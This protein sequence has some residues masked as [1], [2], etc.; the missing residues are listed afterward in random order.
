MLRNRR[1]YQNSLVNSTVTWAQFAPE[2]SFL[3]STAIKV[4]GA[5]RQGINYERRAQEYIEAVVPWKELEPQTKYLKSPWLCYKTK[6]SGEQLLYC[7]PDGLIIQLEQKRCTIVEIKLQ[8]TSEAFYQIKKL[9]QPVLEKVYPDFVFSA[10]E[11][12]KWLDPHTK[13]PVPFKLAEDIVYH[14]VKFGVHIYN[15]GR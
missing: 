8:H 14:D 13:F 4:T 2:P 1:T 9:Y 5:K 3:S 11:I 15:S 6:S 12:V 7:Q 10:L